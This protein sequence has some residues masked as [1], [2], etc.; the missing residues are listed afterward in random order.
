MLAE[1]FHL[2]AEHGVWFDKD[3]RQPFER[4]LSAEIAKHRESRNRDD[5]AAE[6]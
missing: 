6:G 2:C 4:V 5:A 3:A 1:P